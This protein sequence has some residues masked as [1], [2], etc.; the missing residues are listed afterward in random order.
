MKL[1]FG[2]P[3][4]KIKDKIEDVEINCTCEEEAMGIAA[5]CYL[6]GK[7]ATVYSQNSGLCR[8]LDVITSLY[9]PYDIPLPKLIL[10]IRKKPYHHHFIGGITYEILALLNYEN[11]EITEQEE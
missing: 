10:S 11:V 5:G 7:E 8:M 6:A 1:K 4:S 9:L 3:C 2:V